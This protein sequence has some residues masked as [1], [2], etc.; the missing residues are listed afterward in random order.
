MSR[1]LRS[2]WFDRI[3]DRRVGSFF[4]VHRV[5]FRENARSRAGHNEK[6]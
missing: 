1:I 2:Y 6:I 5:I 4:S 3:V